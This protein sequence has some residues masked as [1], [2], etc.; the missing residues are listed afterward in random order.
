MLVHPLLLIQ[1]RKTSASGSIKQHATGK[2]FF[3][4]GSEFSQFC[5]K[6]RKTFSTMRKSTRLSAQNHG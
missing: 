4:S 3:L 5:E 1:F 6:G 2:A